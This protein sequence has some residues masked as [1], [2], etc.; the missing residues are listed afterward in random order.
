MIGMYVCM[1]AAGRYGCFREGRMDG[2]KDVG[3][4]GIQNQNPSGTSS[5]RVEEEVA[6]KASCPFHDTSTL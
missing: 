2:W 4:T 1:Y 5:L 6:A 3:R